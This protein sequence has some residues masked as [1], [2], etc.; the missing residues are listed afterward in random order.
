MTTEPA[1]DHINLREPF[2]GC[3]GIPPGNDDPQRIAMQDRERLPIHSVGKQRRSSLSAVH[4][5]AT[6]EANRFASRIKC[7]AVSTSKHY[8]GRARFNACPVHNLREW[9]A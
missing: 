1:T 9:H 7:A 3:H 8:L 5:Q 6:L 4:A 2:H